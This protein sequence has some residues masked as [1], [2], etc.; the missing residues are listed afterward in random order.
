MKKPFVLFFAVLVSICFLACGIPSL[1]AQEEEDERGFTLEE[2]TVTAQKRE[3]NQQKVAIAIE[4]VSGEELRQLGKINLDD[5]LS[6][7]S[8]TFMTKTSDGWQVSARGLSNDLPAGESSPQ[9]VSV[10]KDG[11]YTYRK[12]AGLTGFYD[13][14]RVEVLLGPQSTM[15]SSNTPGGVVNIITADPKIERYEASGTVEYGNYELLHTEGMVN[16][17]ASDKLAFRAAFST[18]L[19]DGY[20][21]NGQ[22]DED[23]KSARLKALYQANEDLSIM[24]TGEYTLL[25]GQGFG[26]VAPFG[27]EDELDD[28]WYTDNPGGT[29]RDVKTHKIYGRLQWDLDFGTLTLMPSFTKNDQYTESTSAMFGFRINGGWNDETVVEARLTSPTDSDIIWIVGMYWHETDWFS[30]SMGDMAPGT[31]LYETMTHW[32]KSQAIFGN[33]TY[34]FTDRFRLTA[35][36]RIT[37]EKFEAHQ[38][39][40]NP[41]PPPPGMSIKYDWFMDETNPD[42]K[43]GFEYDLSLNS[44]LWAH[45]TTSIRTDARGNATEHLEAYQAGSKNRFMDNKVQVNAS[46]YFYNYTDYIAIDRRSD[47]EFPRLNQTGGP[48]HGDVILYGLDVSTSYIITEKDILNVSASFLHSE[49]T[50]LVFDYLTL[51]WVDY[52]GEPLTNSPDLTVTATYSHVFYLP[53]GGTLTGR[54]DTRYATESYVNFTSQDPVSRVEPS[55]SLTNFSA[56]YRSPDNKYSITGYVKNIEDHAEKRRLDNEEL[57]IGPPRTYGAVLSARF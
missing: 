37:K 1:Y 55:H 3:E 36:A 16:V 5:A 28:P 4:S 44:M 11:V 22:D 19:H 24:L 9:S 17:P 12:D 7:I 15:Y 38:W 51:P 33:I 21:S 32:M 45:F 30:E 8:S 10:N 41:P 35:G 56:I 13:I 31:G 20:L 52:K 18:Q 34:P 25:G 50:R 39:F 6:T 57:G 53:N 42:Y 26:T 40:E 54:V 46:A 27:D 48:K 43:I 23:T 47:P 14:E 29:V 49:F 2:I